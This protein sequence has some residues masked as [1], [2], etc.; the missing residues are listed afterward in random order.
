[1][2]T[3]SEFELRPFFEDEKWTVDT[4][5]SWGILYHR[6]KCDRCK[7][8]HMKYNASSR[9]WR[10]SHRKTCGRTVSVLFESFFR[11]RKLPLGMQMRL[12]YEWLQQSGVVATA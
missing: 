2:A 3:L 1:M 4:L 5:L 12:I 6:E 7:E 8:G 9:L 10:C 11:R